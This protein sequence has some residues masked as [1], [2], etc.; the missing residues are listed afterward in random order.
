MK[1]NLGKNFDSVVNRILVVAMTVMVSTSLVFADPSNAG[2]NFS[3]WGLEQIWYVAL[4]IM[5]VVILKFVIKKAWVPLAV[6]VVIGGIVLVLIKTPDKI[7]SIGT[8]IFNIIFK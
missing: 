5:A 3:S 4:L 6:F 7:L 2:Q 8:S 1:K